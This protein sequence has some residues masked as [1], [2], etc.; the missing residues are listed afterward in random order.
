MISADKLLIASRFH[1]LSYS[2]VEIKTSRDT[3][4]SFSS[5]Y[6]ADMPILSSLLLHAKHASRPNRYQTARQFSLSHHYIR[7]G[8]HPPCRCYI[9][10]GSLACKTPP[11]PP[12][13]SDHLI[14]ISLEC[15]SRNT[16]IYIRLVIIRLLMCLP[17]LQVPTLGTWIPSFYL[18]VPVKT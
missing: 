7:H 8:K 18:P 17:T 12:Q 16:R 14:N 13:D 2:F 6:A 5:A 15:L 11:L 3:S 9:R 10:T 1:S 4:Q